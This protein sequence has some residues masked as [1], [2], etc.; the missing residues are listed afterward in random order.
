MIS[1]VSLNIIKI[2]VEW[3]KKKKE[4]DYHIPNFSSN[5]NPN[6]VK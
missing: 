1:N 3:K 5:F 2:H 6:T 4:L